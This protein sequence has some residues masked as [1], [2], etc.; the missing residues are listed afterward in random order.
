METCRAGVVALAHRLGGCLTPNYANVDKNS[1]GVVAGTKFFEVDN[2]SLSRLTNVAGRFSWTIATWIESMDMRLVSVWIWLAESI[3]MSLGTRIF[4]RPLILVISFSIC[5]LA[6]LVLTRRKERNSIMLMMLVA[7]FTFL[8]WIALRIFSTAGHNGF[9]VR[10]SFSWA[11]QLIK[12]SVSKKIKL[13]SAIVGISGCADNFN[14]AFAFSHGG[15]EFSRQRLNDIQWFASLT[16]A[17][18]WLKRRYCFLKCW[19]HSLFLLLGKG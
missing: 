10:D 18:E 7:P 3:V 2:N 8:D 11:S 16:F 4:N 12:T 19:A 5:A 13:D 15:F 14:T 1:S 17:K 9:P 6:I